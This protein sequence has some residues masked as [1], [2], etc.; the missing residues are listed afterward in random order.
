VAWKTPALSMLEDRE[1]LACLWDLR[2][3]PEFRGR[4]FGHRLFT[5]ALAWAKERNCRQLKVETQNINVPA[6]R[7]YAAQGCALGQI[8]R[9]A[10]PESM[11]E[12]RLV[13]Y[14]SL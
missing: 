12:V 7:F 14:R 13:W 8:D 10:Y 2:V 5:A 4:K 11:N 6:C 9:F 3:S 1:D